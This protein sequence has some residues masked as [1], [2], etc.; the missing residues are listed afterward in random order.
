MEN[1]PSRR[2]RKSKIMG[3]NKGLVFIGLAFELLG[4]VI[5]SV[6]VGN[7]VDDHFKLKGLGI[8]IVFIIGMASWTL[9]LV[10]LLKKF[11]KDMDDEFEDPKP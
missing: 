7:I 1:E 10:V 11:M 2:Q 9:H 6:Y 5:A 4:I 8:G 3:Q